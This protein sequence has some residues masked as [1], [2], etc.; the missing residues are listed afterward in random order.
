MSRRAKPPRNAECATDAAESLGGAR[1]VVTGRLLTL[2]TTELLARL[3]AREGVIDRY[4][5]RGTTHVIVGMGGWPLAADGRVSYAVR[6]AEALNA[7]GGRIRIWSEADLREALGL[8]APPV[9]GQKT[10]TAGRVCT[11]LGLSLETLR[12]WEQLSLVRT[13]AGRYDF[14]DLVS[15]QALAELFA[16]GVEP[17]VIHRSLAGLQRF[18]PDVRRPL[19][20]LAMIVENQNELLAQFG[21]FLIGPDGQLHW[22]FDRLDSPDAAEERAFDDSLLD[23]AAEELPAESWLAQARALRS[24]D[25]LDEARRAARKALL[26]NTRFPAVYVLLADIERESENLAAAFELYRVAAQQQGD[27]AAH[28]IQ[29][30]EVAEEID[31]FED[32]ISALERAIELAPGDADARFLLAMCHEQLAQPQRAAPHWE[33]YFHA[34]AR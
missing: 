10:I 15:L 11:L 21:E 22:R 34:E 26:Q 17:A 19:A 20:Q 7:R 9:A 12:R 27:S 33:A 5:T 28:W 3:Q 32:A 16:R 24:A 14:Q 23:R 30:A 13:R 2:A 8:A 31:R 4:V 29:A 1:L 6:R 18:L 25:R